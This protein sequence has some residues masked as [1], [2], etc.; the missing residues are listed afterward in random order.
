MKD[1]LLPLIVFQSMMIFRVESFLSTGSSLFVKQGRTIENC[2]DTAI[3]ATTTTDDR[4]ATLTFDCTAT[5]TSDSITTKAG[6]PEEVSDFFEKNRNCMVSAGN[7]RE[8]IELEQITE[9][10]LLEWKEKCNDLGAVK[11]DSTSD[12]ILRVKTGGVDF[13]GFSLKSNALIGSKLLLSD[14][15]SGGYPTYEF[16]LIRDE[17]VVNGLGPV[18]WIFKKL[19]GD[20]DEKKKKDRTLASSLSRVTMTGS[21]SD[22]VVFRSDVDFKIQV[23]FPKLLLRIL[24]VSKEKAEAQGSEAIMKTLDKDITAVMKALYKLWEEK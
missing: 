24:P 13:P 12:K 5:F 18:V 19:T 15:S 7:Q 10:L 9:D 2:K 11:P 20:D 22:T 21:S 8:V 14:E 1:A 4:T 3:A 16:T 17:R 6:A 23:T